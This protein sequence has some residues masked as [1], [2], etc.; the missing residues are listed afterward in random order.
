MAPRRGDDELAIDY[1]TRVAGVERQVVQ[2]DGKQKS[3]EDICAIRYQGI[4]NSMKSVK[5]E[6][7]SIRYWGVRAVLA[8]GLL[9][10]VG[11]HAFLRAAL[12]KC[13]GIPL[14]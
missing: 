3:H 11:G 8:L 9:N 5:D 4:E 14:P 13:C 2:L 1:F 12:D 10:L 6:L 7:S